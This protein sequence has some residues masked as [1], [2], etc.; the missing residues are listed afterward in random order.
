MK[1]LSEELN[2][3]FDTEEACLA[4]EADAR[5]AR[6]KEE[7]KRKA[8]QEERK[9]MAAEVEEARK[10]MTAA[11]HTYYEKLDAFIKKYK[12][13]HYTSTDVNDIPTLFDFFDKFIL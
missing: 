9:A 2:R 5:S 1:Y 12:S 4:A 7:E 3:T 11:Q 8:V 10:V 13:Y 6:A